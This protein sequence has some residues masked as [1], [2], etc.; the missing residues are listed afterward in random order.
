MGETFLLSFSSQ[1]CPYPLMVQ[2]P[3]RTQRQSLQVSGPS[4]SYRSHSL[5]PITN[6]CHSAYVGLTELGW[7]KS[8]TWS[9]LSRATTAIGVS[10]PRQGI[11]QLILFS[12]LFFCTLTYIMF[13]GGWKQW[14]HMGCSPYLWDEEGSSHSRACLRLQEG[15]GS[16]SCEGPLV[17]THMSPSSPSCT[18]LDQILPVFSTR[19]LGNS[20]HPSCSSGASGHASRNCHHEHRSSS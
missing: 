18:E 20:L 4:L 19:Q 11:Y 3:G 17:G 15:Q 9:L 5:F 7:Y 10:S 6:P 12:Q 8:W 13:S 1:L 2:W 14:T 16:W